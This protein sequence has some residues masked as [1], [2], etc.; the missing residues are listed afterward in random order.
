M[1]NY[2]HSE[3]YHCI[4]YPAFPR[5]QLRVDSRIA[6]FPERENEQSQVCSSPQEKDL[7]HDSLVVSGAESRPPN[8]WAALASAAL[9]SLLLLALVVIP[10]FHTDTLPN[11]ETVTMLYMPPA[12][13]ASNV[14]RLPAPTSTSRKTPTNLR[15]PT[16]V[17]KTQEAPSPPV[18]S[19]GGLAGGVP[20][21]VVGG[22]PGG[23]LNGVLSNTGSAQALVKTPAPAPKRVRVP[24]QVAEANL[25]HDVAPQ[26]PPEAGRKRIQGTVVL[27]AV[28]DK[29]GTVR[30]VQVVS[31]LPVL[32]QAAI[33]A[34]KQWRYRPYLLNGTP[35][36]VASHITINF[37]LST[38]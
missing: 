32:A 18:D 29:D 37:T 6:A 15:I 3:S 28:I 2:N 34:V 38:S 16:A 27:M 33:D 1:G 30:D 14:T 31:G 24:A 36:E 20:G 12:A 7:F 10:L 13:A 9:L 11:R 25:V 22:I 26:Y 23:V 8:L 35:V 4:A 21:G 19:A 5:P 17:H